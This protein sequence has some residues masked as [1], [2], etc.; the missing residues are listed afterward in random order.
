M[1]VSM[2]PMLTRMYGKRLNAATCVEA[3]RARGTRMLFTRLHASDH[4]APIAWEFS[5]VSALVDAASLDAHR[6]P[7]GEDGLGTQLGGL[8]GGQRK[9]Q[10]GHLG[11]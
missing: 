5:L 7:G 6:L 8:L 4:T 3:P 1:R 2:H 10:V 11:G 9:G